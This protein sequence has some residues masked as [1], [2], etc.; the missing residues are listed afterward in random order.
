[1]RPTYESSWPGAELNV[2]YTI[3][4]PPIQ[5]LQIAG[6]AKP[7]TSQLFDCADRLTLHALAGGRMIILSYY[8]RSSWPGAELTAC[9]GWGPNDNTWHKEITLSPHK[10][11]HVL[12]TLTSVPSEEAVLS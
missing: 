12:V 10:R 6:T 3:P 11:N 9:L 4:P 8:K 7:V 2:Y 1:M 5:S